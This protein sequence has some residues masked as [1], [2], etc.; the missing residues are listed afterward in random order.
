MSE[1][2]QR[3]ILRLLAIEKEQ[4]RLHGSLKNEQRRILQFWGIEKE[5]RR[6]KKE[7]RRISPYKNLLLQKLAPKSARLGARCHGR[8]GRRFEEPGMEGR[9]STY[10]KDK[11]RKEVFDVFPFKFV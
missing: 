3:R 1:D 5:L 11:V 8:R 6:L 10:L 4:L 9:R 2:E 7:P